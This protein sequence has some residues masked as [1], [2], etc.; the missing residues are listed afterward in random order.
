VAQA[1]G[2]QKEQ[3][4]REGGFTD[5]EI[6][7]WRSQ[8][9]R[10][11]TDAGF[12]SQEVGEY[13]GVKEPDMSAM[14]Q[15]FEEN[16]AKGAPGTAP[17]EPPKPAKSF[18]EALD[19]GWQMSVSGLI[20]RG[21]A[22]DVMVPENAGM[23]SRIISQVG[24]LAGDLPAMVAGYYGGSVAGAYGGG[25]A[26]TLAGPEATPFGAAI[27]S[28]VGGSAG[29]FALPAA[30]REILMQ[31]YQKGDIKDF[32]DF[33]ERSSAVLWQATKAGITGAATGGAGVVAGKAFAP[34][35]ST[36]LKY[37]GQAA[38]EVATMVGV[39][40]ALEGQVPSASDFAEA[41]ILVG[42]LHAVSAPIEG[43]LRTIYAKTGLKPDQV[44]QMAIEDPTI[45]Q[46]LASSN[47]EVPKAFEPLVEKP[48][49]EPASPEG[50]TRVELNSK[51]PEAPGEPGASPST[52]TPEPGPTATTNVTEA[53]AK[54][55]S[56][57]GEKAAAEK[58]KY[59]MNQFY[60]DWVDK[61]DPINEAV[62][63]LH[64]NP[65][66]LPADEHPY[67][68]ARM[69]NDFKA[70]TKFALEKGTLDFKTLEQNGKGLKDIIEPF[71]EDLD[72]FSAYLISKRALEVEG[73]GLQSGFDVEAA[74]QVVKEGKA[75]YEQGAK[76][77][78]D[79]Q[80]RNLQ[81]LRDSGV[82]S[83]KSYDALVEAGKSYIPF[84]RII[85]PEGAAAG[86]KGPKRSNALKS[87]SGS[88]KQIQN[89]FVSVLENTET[90]MRMA[91]KNRAVLSFVKMAEGV[92][93]QELIKKVPAAMTPI[94]VKSEEVAKFFK[95]QGIEADPESFTIFR[96]KSKNLS[97]NQF[98]V[99]RD[100]KREVYEAD[101]ELAQAFKSLDGDGTSMHFLLR[102]ARGFTVAKKIGLTL[103]PDFILRNMFRDQLTAGVFTKGGTAPFG[104]MLLAMGDLIQKNDTYYN[105]LKSGGANGTFL[106]LNDKYLSKNV[107]KLNEETGFIDSA[108]NVAKRPVE[109]MRIAGEL[110]EQATRL[111]EF[112]RVSQGESSGPNIFAG[113]YS[114]REVTVDFQRIGAKMSALN[115]IT[116][117]MNVSV[118]GADR[119]VRAIREN[120]GGVTGK[121]VTYITLPSVLLWWANHDDPRWRD[122]PNWEKDL[123]WIVM[124]KDHIYRIPK[125][126]EL[127][128][129]FGTG[130]ERM[131]EKFFTD[132]PTALK[133]FDKTMVGIVAPSFVPD[134]IAPAIEQYFNKSLFTGHRIVPDQME[135]I[136]PEYQ[137]SDYTSESAKAL[138]KM[139]A[140]VPGM[141]TSQAASPM[142]I[143]N[144]VRAWSGT[145]GQYAL[146]VADQALIKSGAVPDP[147]KP[148]YT[149]ADIPAVK[150]FM[151]RYPSAS[152][153]SIQDFQ[154]RYQ[155]NEQVIQTIHYLA[156]SGDLV[157][158]QQELVL[159]ANQEKLF[160]L[161][162][163]KEAL[164]NQNRFIRLIYKNPDL[165]P[166]KK[167]EL[168]DGV[169]HMMIEQ[170]HVG[171]QLSDAIEKAL[172]EGAQSK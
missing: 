24:T 86:K 91:E 56:Q 73:R 151:V 60:K 117:F 139:V 81:Y 14:R 18:L 110:T 39:G 106:E 66:T 12:N 169:Y 90:L 8:T 33:Y 135:K 2:L 124:T 11:L 163:I 52:P 16:L 120:P 37:T 162:G 21:K 101:P 48:A 92:S 9:V 59:G 119:A 44:A 7:Q 113:G 6:D 29:A 144:Y 170:A 27:G 161:T 55:L 129:V 150:A 32:N 132:N 19:A 118:Q 69:A 105:W 82:L 36:V 115:A 23:A 61:L 72:G 155:K 35:S 74:K 128:I 93:D 40:R 166:D 87:F 89:P 83:D 63:T 137:Y 4:L 167:R 103:T 158:L 164:S 85:E 114:A 77:L 46:D 152:A 107:F 111:A 146:Q 42:G 136:L 138:G 131:L 5:T 10:S 75:Q 168:I 130:P 3:A 58:P 64:D 123:F 142:V 141:R 100:G 41:A 53:Q 65:D 67:Q 112:K 79:F 31:H 34:L 25:A 149:L 98:E 84:S 99:F 17:G 50:A 97:D 134:A 49:G 104:G 159:Q 102:M 122:I 30:I 108:W 125:P 88:E 71:R 26:A 76:E 127:G 68:L 47:I 96:Q 143:D 148:T 22:P 153:Q 154:D 133:D 45:K 80:N 116:A 62:K 147:I 15:H 171:N 70:K 172:K 1:A 54:I 95:S 160:A 126:Q 13:F 109:L 156:K 20:G 57:V 165:T 78:V 140:T 94:D 121:A 145:L 51:L 28:K 43:K 38:A 157:H